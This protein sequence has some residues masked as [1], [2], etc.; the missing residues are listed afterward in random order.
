MV[1]EY[2]AGRPWPCRSVR[3]PEH[4]L[5][6]ARDSG[7]GFVVKR[8]PCLGWCSPMK[9]LL[10]SSDGWEPAS[11]RLERVLKA[12]SLEAQMFHQN[13]N[14]SREWRYTPM[15]LLCFDHSSRGRGAVHQMI[16]PSD[17]IICDAYG[18]VSCRSY[19]VSTLRVPPP[20]VPERSIAM[21]TWMKETIHSLSIP[22]PELCAS[23]PCPGVLPPRHGRNGCG[24]LS[25]EPSHKDGKFPS[26]STEYG[27]QY[28]KNSAGRWQ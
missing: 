15:G 3:W 8:A 9:L 21:I 10:V 27:V 5:H 16:L 23:R 2:L 4:R 28:S 11:L 25:S 14:V 13:S 19:N 12:G 18:D 6:L 22:R 24:P 17:G 26:L 20:W 7:R 1:K